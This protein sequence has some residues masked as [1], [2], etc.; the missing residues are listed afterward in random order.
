[1]LD[2][3]TG[4]CRGWQLEQQLDFAC[5][6]AALNCVAVGARGG[7]ETLEAIERLMATGFALWI[8]SSHCS[9]HFA[10]DHSSRWRFG[11]R[12]RTTNFNR[13][14]QSRL[15][16]CLRGAKHSGAT[17]RETGGRRQYAL[18]RGEQAITRFVGWSTRWSL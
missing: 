15:D 1:M 5:A 4:C 2:L 14:E 3:F 11:S 7:I 13:A 6:A 16:G 17:R 18:L 8:S 9:G 10:E 12:L